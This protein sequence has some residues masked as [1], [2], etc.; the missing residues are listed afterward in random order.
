M[1]DK[2][3]VRVFTEGLL[4]TFV[5]ALVLYVLRQHVVVALLCGI[6][7]C[8]AVIAII[9]Y[10]EGRDASKASA[11]ADRK[12]WVYGIEVNVGK[13][14]LASLE[15]SMRRAAAGSEL[16]EDD[17]KP[18][19]QS[20]IHDA[21]QCF[22]WGQNA[23]IDVEGVAGKTGRTAFMA[24]GLRR[25]R[26]SYVGTDRASQIWQETASRLDWLAEELSKP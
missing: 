22:T 17:K 14:F 21:N 16:S 3:A 5:G 12:Q 6:I 24:H 1:P 26:P 4:V 8:L 7:A 13:Q 23:M 10:L 25:Q 2:R 11:K 19:E 20:V 15:Q 18:L 9:T